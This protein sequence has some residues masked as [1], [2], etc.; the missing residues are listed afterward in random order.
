MAI[1]RKISIIRT[2]V[3]FIKISFLIHTCEVFRLSISKQHDY[4]ERKLDELLK[5]MPD[6]VVKYVDAKQD[7]LALPSPFSI[8]Y[9]IIKSF[10]TGSRLKGL[11]HVNRLETSHL[12]ILKTYLWRKLV[13]I[14]NL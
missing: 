1:I 2:I 7:I 12:D 14:L 6:Y 10:L 8:M 4:Y 9:G 11:S 3:L 5:E 13:I